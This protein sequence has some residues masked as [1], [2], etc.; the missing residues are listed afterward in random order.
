MKSSSGRFLCQIFDSFF[1]QCDYSPQ[2]SGLFPRMPGKKIRPPI[3]YQRPFCAYSI[4]RR[5]WC[6]LLRIRR[7]GSCGPLHD[8]HWWPCGRSWCSCGSGSHELPCADASWAEK[9]SS[10]C[11]SSVK[12]RPRYGVYSGPKMGTGLQFNS[13]SHTIPFCQAFFSLSFKLFW[14]TSVEKLSTFSPISRGKLFIHNILWLFSTLD[15]RPFPRRRYVFF[16]YYKLPY[17][18]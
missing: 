11:I 15:T 8:E 14:K 4:L 3:Q 16:M 12:T 7:S 1:R 9:F 17:I 18:I 6:I 2:L 13:I 10:W 5:T